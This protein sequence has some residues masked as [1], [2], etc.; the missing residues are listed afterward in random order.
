MTKGKLSNEH[1]AHLAMVF[2][3]MLKAVKNANSSDISL[4]FN[5]DEKQVYSRLTRNIDEFERI[6]RKRFPKEWESFFDDTGYAFLDVITLMRDVRYADKVKDLFAMMKLF[7]DGEA[8]ILD[9]DEV[10]EIPKDAL[11]VSEPHKVIKF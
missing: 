9:E 4:L 11:N 7:A 8:R 1:Q 10:S 2:M 5:K 6:L 3:F